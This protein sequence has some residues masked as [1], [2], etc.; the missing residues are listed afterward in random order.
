VHKYVVATL[1]DIQASSR[2][3]RKKA[4]LAQTRTVLKELTALSQIAVATFIEQ[5]QEKCP[6]LSERDLFRTAEIYTK[7]ER[8]RSGYDLLKQLQECSPQDLDAWNQIMQRWTAGN[9][10][11]V[12]S[13]LEH[14]LKLIAR[15]QSLITSSKADELH[16]LQPLFE[17]GLW[18]FGPE[19]DAVDFHSNRYLATIIRD[20]LGGTEQQVAHRRPDFV[21][22]PDRSIGIYSAAFYEDRGEISGIRQILVV[23]LKKGGFKLSQKE[24]D[25]ARDY[26]KELCKA[27]D[28]REDAKIVA[29][30]LGADGEEGLEQA[31]YG[32]RIT[33]VPMLYRTLLDRAH[34]R[35]FNLHRKIELLGLV[36]PVD[37]QLEEVL[38]SPEQPELEPLTRAKL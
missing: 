35:T 7:L 8:A 4:A 31:T 13:E 38:S 12:L 36:K 11:I 2:K 15:L 14:R 29:Y 5:V 3:D 25:Q 20:S 6:T 28:V 27:A 37:E 10:E 34:S 1:N 30:V 21:A 26:S 19:Y 22:L 32:N 16:D 17:R 33:I 18:M 9:A 23:E 24:L